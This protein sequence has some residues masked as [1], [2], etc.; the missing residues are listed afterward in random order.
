MFWAFYVGFSTYLHF[1]CF[2]KG[3]YE[4]GFMVLGSW[5]WMVSLGELE[6]KVGWY[7]MAIS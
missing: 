2:G 7:F 6:G 4:V 5:P 1:C 3:C